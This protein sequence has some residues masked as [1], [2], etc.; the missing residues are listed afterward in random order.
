MLRTETCGL[1]QE[2]RERT[3]RY[4]SAIIQHFVKLVTFP[5]EPGAVQ[6]FA[7]GN[8][9]LVRLHLYEPTP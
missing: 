2:F 5:M 3:K 6:A 1:S 8:L 4:A 7:Q 9:A